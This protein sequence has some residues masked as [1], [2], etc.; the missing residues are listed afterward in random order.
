MIK[1]WIA[2]EN[3][4]TLVSKKYID[5]RYI[6]FWEY[7]ITSGYDNYAAVTYFHWFPDHS[8]TDYVNGKNIDLYKEFNNL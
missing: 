1:C 7:S 6:E 8:I 3:W 4:F 5:C 2:L